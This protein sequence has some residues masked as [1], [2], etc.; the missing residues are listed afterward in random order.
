MMGIKNLSIYL[1]AGWWQ[2]ILY[3]WKEIILSAFIRGSFMDL[4]Y[5]HQSLLA[6][7]SFPIAHQGGILLH[8]IHAIEEAEKAN[9]VLANLHCDI[10][11]IV[12][13][14]FDEALCVEDTDY[15][16]F[17]EQ[18]VHMCRYILESRLVNYVDQCERIEAT[19]ACARNAVAMAEL[20]ADPT[21]WWK[22]AVTR[23]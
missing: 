7:Q 4:N 21:C 5:A 2:D 9:P 8:M 15:D 18:F 12:M 22:T 3:V 23:C 17:D 16:L 10:D 1:T 20:Y 6:V 13:D 14:W 11:R 19:V